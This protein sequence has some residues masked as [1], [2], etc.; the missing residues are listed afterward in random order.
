MNDLVAALPAQTAREDLGFPLDVVKEI[1][2]AVQRGDEKEHRRAEVVTVRTRPGLSRAV[3]IGPD[4]TE[5]RK[6]IDALPKGMI[7]DRATLYEII[8]GRD[9]PDGT[10][11]RGLLEVVYEAYRHGHPAARRA[12]ETSQ[13][14][15]REMRSGGTRPQASPGPEVS[16]PVPAR[17]GDLVRAGP[18]REATP[19]LDED[20][21][22]GH[23]RGRPRRVGAP[24]LGGWPLVAFFGELP[25]DAIDGDRL[26]DWWRVEVVGKRSEKTGLNLLGVLSH[27][28]K[29][30][31]QTKVPL[32]PDPIRA[33]R[34]LL[35][36]D[37]RTKGLGP[38]GSPRCVPWS[39]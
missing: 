3:W 17:R 28:L 1:V 20:L 21:R 27:V 10:H 31:R 36:D 24:L 38:R 29:Y 7:L 26:L 12:V 5:T 14:I 34:E 23:C 15:Q 6:E 18:G 13:A 8:A 22:L 9:R 4:D 32:G 19:L 35:H 25:L 39:P 37:Q 2:T 30:A 33:F 11:D 16:Q